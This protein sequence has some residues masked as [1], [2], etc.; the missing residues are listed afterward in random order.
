[1]KETR[2]AID[3]VEQLG[4]HLGLVELILNAMEHGNRVRI[5]KRRKPDVEKESLISKYSHRK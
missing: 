1:M 5:L 2:D 3:P 4:V